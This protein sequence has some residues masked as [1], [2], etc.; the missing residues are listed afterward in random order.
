MK[1]IL[2]GF[3]TVE[4]SVPEMKMI[5][6]NTN[7]GIWQHNKIYLYSKVLKCAGLL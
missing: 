1:Q 4:A 6:T 5:G 2:S 7:Y 3:D